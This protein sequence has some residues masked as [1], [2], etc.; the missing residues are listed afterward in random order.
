VADYPTIS[1]SQEVQAFYERMRD[2][3]TSHSLAEVF[4][5][6]QSPGIAGTDSNFFAG[7]HSGNH[8]DRWPGPVRRAYLAKAKAAGVDISGCVYLP[9][10]ARFPGDP[11]AWV[12]G[13]GDVKKLC[14][15]QNL[16]S[17]GAVEHQAD[18][19]RI[20]ETAAKRSVPIAPDIVERELA[21]ELTKHPEKKLKVQETRE[22]V[23]DRIMPSWKKNSAL[24][25]V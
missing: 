3:G 23:A 16:T 10:L 19:S 12:R 1:D 17:H 13:R 2:E 14:E 8:L 21:K 24:K 15:Q 4:A 5:T 20:A 18:E 25:V 22:E 7:L 6:Q 9:S 11:L